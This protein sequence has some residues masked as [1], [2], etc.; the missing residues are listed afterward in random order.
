MSDEMTFTEEEIAQI[1]RLFPGNLLQKFVGTISIEIQTAI[2]ESVGCNNFDELK[3]LIEAGRKANER[4]DHLLESNDFIK[5]LR[6]KLDENREE[7]REF[8]KGKIQEA[9]REKLNL[10]END[11]A[12]NRITEEIFAERITVGREIPMFPAIVSLWIDQQINQRTERIRE[13]IGAKAEGNEEHVLTAAR[14]SFEKGLPLNDGGE[15]ESFVRQEQ[16]GGNL[17]ETNEPNDDDSVLPA[18]S[19]EIYK[20]IVAFFEGIG[21]EFKQEGAHELSTNFAKRSERYRK[22]RYLTAQIEDKRQSGKL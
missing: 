9:V 2:L 15:F 16:S 3:T 10:E 20:L 17:P 22:L 8:I 6:K 21:K 18:D 7:G 19:E 14:I 12:L 5:E 4:L 1:L 13:I 11:K